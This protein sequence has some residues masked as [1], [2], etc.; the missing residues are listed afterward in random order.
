MSVDYQKMK[1]HEWVGT[2][3]AATTS[4]SKDLITRLGGIPPR[5]VTFRLVEQDVVDV[6]LDVLPY[7]KHRLHVLGGREFLDVFNPRLF[8]LSGVLQYQF[9]FAQTHTNKSFS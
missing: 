2:H 3:T 7:G 4:Y 1:R 6:L 9:N 5:D 8:L